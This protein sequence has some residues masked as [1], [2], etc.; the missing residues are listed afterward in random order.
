MMASI[1]K[2]APPPALT[3]P[4]LP[5]QGRFF[6]DDLIVDRAMTGHLA[7]TELQ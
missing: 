3:F 5:Y 1:M 7:F 2:G 4:A 6:S